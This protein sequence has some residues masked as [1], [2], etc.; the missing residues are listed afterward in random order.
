[1][2]GGFLGMADEYAARKR[3]SS[4]SYSRGPSRFSTWFDR[5]FHDWAAGKQTKFQGFITLTI[6]WV[7]GLSPLWISAVFLVLVSKYF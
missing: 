3:V 4:Y 5:R 2:R 6:L 7:V 1:M